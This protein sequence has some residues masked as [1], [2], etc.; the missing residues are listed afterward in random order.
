MLELIYATQG[1]LAASILRRPLTFQIPKHSAGHQ[2]CHKYTNQ[3]SRPLLERPR[4]Q[5][6]GV[7][8]IDYADPGNERVT[9]GA[10]RAVYD[11]EATARDAQRA[12][13]K[14]KR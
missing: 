7:P 13:G 5:A 3:R 4:P 1:C 8:S 14:C 2:Q 6:D 12:G 9:Q 10:S 11:Q